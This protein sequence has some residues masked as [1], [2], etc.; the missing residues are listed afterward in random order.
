[1]FNNI[2]KG[3]NIEQII[4]IEFW[5]HNPGPASLGELI[6]WLTV[7]SS[8]ALVG[9][10]ILLYNRYK[11]GYYPPKNKIFKPVGIGLVIIGAFGEVFS[12][13]RWQ[14]IDFLGVRA[15]LLLIFVAVLSW[16]IFFV[17]IYRKRV[18]SQS[19]AYEARAIKKKYLS[20]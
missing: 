11:I 3:I 8:T 4:Q 17:L 2:I 9:F 7:F 1:M 19:M 14:G 20:K 13:F 18:P 16:S 15:I 12:L 6:F 10:L 5:F